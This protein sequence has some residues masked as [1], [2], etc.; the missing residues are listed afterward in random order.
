MKKSD[1]IKFLEPYP[2]DIEIWMDDGYGVSPISPT[3]EKTSIFL[4][5]DGWDFNFTDND[6]VLGR[7]EVL[8]IGL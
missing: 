5:E 3:L 1:L 6:K 7:K 2:D 4:T 8:I